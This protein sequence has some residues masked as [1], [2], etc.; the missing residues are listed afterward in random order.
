[1][2]DLQ[3]RGASASVTPPLGIHTKSAVVEVKTD[4][5]TGEISGGASVFD[6]MLA[7]VER[8]ALQSVVKDLMP[9]SRTA[10][11]LRWRLSADSSVGVLKSRQYQTAHYSGLQVCGRVW[12]CPVCAAK[13]VERRRAEIIGAMAVH[14][15][16]GGGVFLM[17]LTAPHQRLDCLVDLLAKH[18]QALRRFWSLKAVR[19]VLAEMASVGQIRAAEVTHGRR[20]RFNN[21]WHPHHHVLLFV[22]GGLVDDSIRNEWAVRLYRQWASSCDG[23]GLGVPSP[24]HGLRLDDGSKASAYVSKWGLEDEMTKGHTKKASKGETPFD[25][26]RAI[27]SDPRDKQARALFVE[28]AEAFKGKR[29]LIWSPGLKRLFGVGE[30]SDEEL[31]TR[32]DEPA[33]LLGS[34]NVQQWRLVLRAEGRGLVL[35]LAAGADGWEAVERYLSGLQA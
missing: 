7:R 26:L 16:S 33:L 18:H 6:P 19:K 1:M 21:G 24:A 25:F 17:T 12:P 2:L 28:F 11:C 22:G 9:L 32:Q 8:F 23:C 13:I 10:G 35:Q 4:L 30:V 20:S 15:V 5:E 27:L 29:Q 14:R 3:N 34:L 31:A